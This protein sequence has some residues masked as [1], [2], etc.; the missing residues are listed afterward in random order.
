MSGLGVGV[1]GLGAF[2]SRVAMRLLWSG[3]HTLQVYDVIDITARLFCN[4][5]GAMAAGSPKMMSQA[6][7]VV[8]TV[9]P[10]ADELREVCFGWEGLGKGFPGGGVVIDLGVTDPLQTIE[11]ARDLKTRGIDFIDAPAFGT[12]DDAKQGTLSLVVGG[13]DAAIELCRPVLDTL[14]SK[15]LRAG[16]VGSAQ[17]AMALVDF[18]RGAAILAA[19]EAIRL[20]Q[21]FG[22]TAGELLAITEVLGGDD[23]S[24]T[25]REEVASRRFGSGAPLGI[26]RRNLDLA[27][28]LAQAAS[29]QSPLLAATEAAWAEAEER[30]GWGADYTSIIRWLEALPSLDRPEAAAERPAISSPA[31]SPK[32]NARGTG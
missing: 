27:G 17:A 20:G 26:L 24:R 32:D 13:E 1:I 22:F 9:L 15:I 18:Q 3:H 8:I 25:L 14:G 23:V 19:S 11:I 30:I 28:R 2:G 10:S 29:L 31:Q 21:H 16:A 4:D 6:C 5:F 12:R 7:N